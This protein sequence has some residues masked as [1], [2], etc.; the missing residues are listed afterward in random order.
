MKNKKN[1]IE[2][3]E[4]ELKEIFAL[5]TSC[6]RYEYNQ[7][8]SGGEYSY[9]RENLDEE[10]EFCGEKR[11]IARDAWRAVLLFLHRHGYSLK[12]GNETFDLSFAFK[13]LVE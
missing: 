3:S 8:Y 9:H 4:E 12:K 7:V 1:I 13:E 5:I 10:Y 11:E 6:T 2:L